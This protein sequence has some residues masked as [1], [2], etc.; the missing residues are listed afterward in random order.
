VHA[1]TDRRVLL[2]LW[3]VTAFRGEPQPLDAAALRWVELPAL[4]V[5]GL[6]EA[7]RPMIA[8]LRAARG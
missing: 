7:D 6:L 1:Y 4:E 8:A 2:D 5:A 3:L